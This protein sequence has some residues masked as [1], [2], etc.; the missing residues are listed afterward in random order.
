V[1]LRG[2]ARAGPWV[3]RDFSVGRSKAGI[4]A[5]C[6]CDADGDPDAAA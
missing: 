4:V 1:R 2:G 3:I 5:G 6:A